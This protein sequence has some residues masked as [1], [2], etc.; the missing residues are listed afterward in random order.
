[1]K[2]R[3]LKYILHGRSSLLPSYCIFA[4]FQAIL[5]REVHQFCFS[6]KKKCD[7]FVLQSKSRDVFRC[8]HATI[9]AF[10]CPSIS[11]SIGP[12][13]STSQK[14]KTRISA[15]AHLS[16]TGGRVSILVFSFTPLLF[17]FTIFRSSSSSS[18]SSSYA[19]SSSFLL[20]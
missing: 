3:Y 13:V 4:H 16:E 10:V 12:S 6:P 1:M 17:L 15:P 14:V 9:R 19:S 18:S 2:L 5:R 7:F 20:A 8:G 11:Q